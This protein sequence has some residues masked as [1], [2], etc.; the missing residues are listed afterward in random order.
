LIVFYIISHSH[1]KET[2][3]KQ[4]F[5][6]WRWFSSLKN[7]HKR[8]KRKEKVKPYNVSLLLKMFEMTRRENELYNKYTFMTIE[9]T[10]DGILFFSSSSSRFK[11][12]QQ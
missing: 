6:K 2:K 7:Y 1:I 3:K 12:K 11:Y 5:R 10:T 8:K 4:S 9:L